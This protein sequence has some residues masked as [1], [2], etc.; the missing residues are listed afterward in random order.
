MSGK[1]IIFSAPSGAGK[2]TIVQHLLTKNLSLEFSVS[3]TS[4]QPR[5]VEKHGVDYY[6]LSAEKFRE[7]IDNKEFIEHEEVYKDLYYGT[8]RSEINRISEKGNNI[9]FDV[10]VVGGLNIKKQFGDRALAIFIAPPSIDELLKRLNNRGT[11][12]PEMIA[13]RVAKAEHEMS[14]AAQ[15]DVVVVNDDLLKAKDEAEAIIRE[16][17][18]K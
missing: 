9:I 14:F 12:T 6:Y 5:G 1:L 3:A 7:H 10:D 18:N 11:D 13:Q 2:S 17:L 4:R 16:F 15:F 8:L